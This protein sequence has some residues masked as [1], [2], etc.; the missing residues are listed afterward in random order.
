MPFASVIAVF[1]AIVP[2]PLPTDIVTVT[3]ET[4]ALLA[5]NA[6]TCTS[7]KA[8]EVIGVPIAV[9]LS[10]DT[11]ESEF[12]ETGATVKVTA[13]A[14]LRILVTISEGLA[15]VADTSLLF[16]RALNAIVPSPLSVHRKICD[17]PIED[18]S[19]V[20]DVGLFV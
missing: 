1:P 4:G 20:S 14:V 6:R 11:N 3:P 17:V 5:S 13:A 12:V 18:A 15:A 10:G 8:P 2:V 9:S 16:A 19:A 7:P